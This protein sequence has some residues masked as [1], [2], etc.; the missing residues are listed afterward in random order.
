[1]AIG[2]VRTWRAI[3]VF[4]LDLVWSI[5]DAC[6]A[7]RRSRLVAELGPAA[8]LSDAGAISAV[9]DAL[10]HERCRCLRAMLRRRPFWLSGHLVLARLSLELGDLAA[11]YASAQAAVHLAGGSL[12]SARAKKILGQCY[13]RGGDCESA[14][15]VFRDVV[16][17]LGDD[18]EAKEELAAAYMALGD[19]ASAQQV[20]KTIPDHKL[21]FQAKAAL[22]CRR[23]PG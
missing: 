14:A 16:A 13:L 2:I 20:L 15:A 19:G 10:A 8:A 9:D 11:A 22:M 7:H 12:V 23:D 6:I 1:M 4:W 18:Y 3:S 17:A 21:S 5:S